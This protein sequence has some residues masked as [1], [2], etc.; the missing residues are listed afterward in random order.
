MGDIDFFVKKLDTELFEYELLD[1]ELLNI[2]K[3]KFEYDGLI[4]ECKDVINKIIHFFDIYKK[5]DFVYHSKQL[6]LYKNLKTNNVNSLDNN[7]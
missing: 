6:S 4:I 5:N 2:S 1:E 3:D 7:R